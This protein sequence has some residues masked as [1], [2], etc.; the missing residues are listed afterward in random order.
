MNIEQAT[1][2]QAH[3]DLSGL[4]EVVLQIQ[5]ACKV[6]HDTTPGTHTRAAQPSGMPTPKAATR[7]QWASPN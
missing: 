4:S 1:I 3:V 5:V 2:D 7:L 6:T